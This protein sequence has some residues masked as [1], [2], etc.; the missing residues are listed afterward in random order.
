MDTIVEN[1]GFFVEGW[2]VPPVK[3]VI[4]LLGMEPTHLTDSVIWTC[5]IYNLPFNRKSFLLLL[6][7]PN[8]HTKCCSCLVFWIYHICSMLVVSVSKILCATNICFNFITRCNCSLI[9]YIIFVTL[10]RA[11]HWT[12]HRPSVGARLDLLRLR[13]TSEPSI[14]SAHLGHHIWHSSVRYFYIMS[15]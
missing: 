14:V 11:R 4:W 13:A 12:R 1:F 9:N 3:Y 5:P 15:V 8:I 10:S 6:K 7:L 2:H